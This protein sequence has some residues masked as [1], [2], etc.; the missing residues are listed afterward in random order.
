MIQIFDT[1]THLNVEE[2]EGRADEELALAAEMG[3]TR[4]NVVGFDRPTI[5]RA[6][7]LATRYEQVYATIGWHPT[8]AGTYTDEVEQ[9]LR[10]QLQH[11]KVIALGEIGLDYYWMTA[12]KEVQEQVF[13]RQIALAKELDLP[14][15]VHTRDALE[16][17]YDIIKSEGVGLR[18]GIMH[19][20]SGSLEMAERFI[21]L[22]MTI[23]FSGV[24]TFKKATDI[25]EAATHLPLDKILVETDAPYLAPVPKRGRENRTAYTRYVVD[26]IAELRGLSSEEVASRTYANAQELFG[27]KD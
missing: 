2:F 21:K 20:Y 15:V 14:F 13:R 1:H 5:K 3:V 10:E 4:M 25:Q 17:T 7:D 26:K 27:L 23:S 8:E 9:F 12:P 22:G 6:L 11:D 18:G 24:V 19:S 16:D